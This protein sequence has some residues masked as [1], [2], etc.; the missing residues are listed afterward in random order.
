MC[1]DAFYGLIISGNEYAKQ[2]QIVASGEGYWLLGEGREADLGFL[3]DTHS[4]FLNFVPLIYE[5]LK[6]SMN[7]E[8]KRHNNNNKT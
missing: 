5:L 1:V 2:I 3:L 8:G 6:I 4:C 7:V